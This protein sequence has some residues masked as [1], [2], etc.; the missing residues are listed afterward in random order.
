MGMW[1]RGQ[2]GDEGSASWTL[3]VS[4]GEP[5]SDTWS[6]RGR[7]VDLE[8]LGGVGFPGLL[9]LLRPGRPAGRSLAEVVRV[10]S[11][12]GYLAL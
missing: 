3:Q 6:G 1:G 2:G 8:F 10:I 5:R 12:F 9:W 4:P 11:T 7:S